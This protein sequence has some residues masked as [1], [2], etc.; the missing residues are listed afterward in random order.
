MK[1]KILNIVIILMFVAGLSIALY[2][3]VSNW[4]NERHQSRAVDS[5]LEDVEDL[6]AEEREKMYEDAVAY[7]AELAQ[8]SMSL[9]L[10]NYELEQYNKT[11]DVTGTGIMGYV[12]IPKIDVKLPIYHGTDEAIL[13]VGAGHIAGTSLPVG[14]ESTHCVISGHSGLPSAKLFTDITKLEAGDYFTITTLD[15]TLT[16]EVDQIRIVLP[17]EL[18]DL[19]IEE[20]QDYCTLVTCTP[21]GINTHRLLVRGHRTTNIDEISMTKEATQLNTTYVAI[22]LAVIIVFFVFLLIDQEGRIRTRWLIFIF[23]LTDR[24]RDFFLNLFGK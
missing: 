12:D 5:Y 19:K 22:V 2:P 21:Y 13:Q 20:G 7:N 6:S 23:D 9:N 24:I 16:Y 8:K 18:S 1:G 4:W 11:L 3:T 15:K 14:G 17:Y 10:S